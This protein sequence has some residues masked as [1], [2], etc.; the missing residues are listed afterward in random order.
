LSDL[1]PQTFVDNIFLSKAEDY[2]NKR[3]AF[4]TIQNYLYCSE[5]VGFKV[6]P[7]CKVVQLSISI[8]I[9]NLVRFEYFFNNSGSIISYPAALGWTPI[10]RVG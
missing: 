5:V 7:N 3:T 10:V 8:F 1:N 2:K 6:K 4:M 9:L